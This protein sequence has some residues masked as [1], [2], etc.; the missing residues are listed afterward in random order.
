MNRQL[1]FLRF[2]LTLSLEKRDLPG[3]VKTSCLYLTYCIG[4]PKSKPLAI[5]ISTLFVLPL[6]LPKYLRGLNLFCVVNMIFVIYFC[7]LVAYEANDLQPLSKSFETTSLFQWSGFYTTFPSSVVAY[8]SH[9]NVLD[10]FQVRR[11]FWEYL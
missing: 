10:V 9:N 8:M 6:S 7:C 4:D 1:N 11:V 3:L 5:L 2:H